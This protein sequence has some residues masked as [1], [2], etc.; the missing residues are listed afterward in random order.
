MWTKPKVGQDTVFVPEK[1]NFNDKRVC[2]KAKEEHSLGFRFLKREF[3]LTGEKFRKYEV[4]KQ[5]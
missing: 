5:N 4:Q 3:V 1:L 2:H